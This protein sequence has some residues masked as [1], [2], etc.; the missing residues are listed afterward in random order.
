MLLAV[1]ASAAPLAKLWITGESGTGAG[2]TQI[3]LGIAADPRLPGHIFVTETG[4]KRI[5]E[6]DP[7]G[8]FVKA[9][10]WG[11]RDGGAQLQACTA[12]TG[13]ME[14]LGGS[15]AGQIDSPRGLAVDSEGNIFVFEATTARV[16]KF[17]PDGNFLLM[18]G[19]GVDQ[20]PNHPG[21]VCTAA[22]LAEG[23]SCGAGST[24]PAPG[25]FAHRDYLGNS[26]AIDSNDTIYVGDNERIEKF[27]SKGEFLGEVTSPF[28][29]GKGLIESLAI[30]GSGHFY[31]A[32]QRS[33]EPAFGS[34]PDVFKMDSTGSQICTLKVAN[35]KGLT[36]DRLGN[37]YV[38]DTEGAVFPVSTVEQFDPSCT[39]QNLPFAGDELTN[40][41][42]IGNGSA[43]L[44][45]GSDIYVANHDPGSFGA[46]PHFFI[47]AYGPPPDDP[48]CPPPSN[49]PTI[50]S[51]FATSAHTDA[52]TVKASINP[53]F[54]KDTVAYVEYGTGACSL[55]A[56][57]STANAPGVPLG[58]GVIDEYVTSGGVL[59]PNLEAGTEYHYRFVAKSSG[60]GPVYGVDPDGDGPGRANFEE[61]LEGTFTTPLPPAAEVDNCPNIAYRQGPASRLGDCRAYE[62]VSPV[63]KEES[64]ILTLK[65]VISL[66]AR[67][68]RAAGSGERF[69][70]STFRAFGDAQSS[71]YV[72][73]YLA[74]RGAAGW[75]NHAISP[76]R[77]G[78]APNDTIA[79]E[80]EF[81]YFS[82]DLA[83]AWVV[84]FT[85][86]LLAP[87]A[88]A[89]FNNLYHRDNPTDTYTAL[90][91]SEPQ[92]TTPA[93]YQIEMQGASADGSHTV[94]RTNDHAPPA[95][96]AGQTYQVYESVNGNL[97]P[98]CILPNKIR[99]KL[100]CSAGTLN[101]G[102]VER[103]A[104]LDHAISDDG[105]R[106]FWSNMKTNIDTGKL[107]VRI[108][109]DRTVAV[110]DAVNPAKPPDQASF[111]TAAADGSKAIF[112][113]GD[114]LYE[115]D[116][117]TRTA[118]LIA[119]GVAGVAGASDDASR[120]Y[121]VSRETLGGGPGPQ[122][123][124]PNLYLYEAGEPPVFNYVAT[125]AESDAEPRGKAFSPIAAEPRFNTARVSPDGLHLAF[126][127]TAS[128]TGKDNADVNSGK[129]DAEVFVFD[130]ETGLVCVSCNRTGARPM[131]RNIQDEHRLSEAF[132]VAAQ[133]PTAESQS[134][135]SRFFSDD[136][137]RLFFESIQPL[138]YGD[139][140]GKRD[141]YEW[142]ALGKGTCVTALG[143]YAP[144][145]AG[146]VT[147]ISS[148]GSTQDSELID[149]SADGSDVFFTTS[150]S[151][152]PQDPG[153][154]DVYDARVQGGFPQPRKTVVCEG[155]ACQAPPTPPND[156][157]P[158]SA[159]FNGP[160]NAPPGE[161]TECP[162]RRKRVKHHDKVRCLK[163]RH[164]K[165]RGSDR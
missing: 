136:G 83:Q 53:H 96:V 17:D 126:M 41:T 86:P 71:P 57:T 45:S 108:D 66:P 98:V 120:V 103:S 115:F 130:F 102:T 64:D 104:T 85:E 151:L 128:L 81:K 131:G 75:Q 78:S 159:I 46:P 107:Y 95:A 93:Q 4:N 82:E 44:T 29:A 110:S 118:K 18:F 39:N 10:G 73:Q 141:V 19:G 100:S 25:E 146:C 154:V 15:G 13:C 90:S 42:G 43:C 117:E 80:S 48:A 63:D 32:F 142:E 11:V 74:Q 61:G 77:E 160:G 58:A 134:Y 114:K 150:A 143:S 47:R 162:R 5:S 148:G 116:V 20:G 3:P 137:R 31:V 14:G 127:S 158:S 121:L 68:D 112:T 139:T 84:H 165:S 52:A 8:R 36:T 157:T 124:K 65:N 92:S 51:Q 7:W 50:A 21:N 59:L 106:I 94:F 145:L 155:E 105:S 30:D 26:I 34:G 38:I 33:V 49:P 37:A 97:N 101:S 138:A 35:P 76:P 54:W 149:S 87:G 2:Q 23:D 79:L 144:A 111:W 28:L 91:T 67:R 119:A 72:S 164:V 132:W 156:P 153:L 69:T 56:C 27:D 62:M 16:Q 123:G 89:G 133:I 6:F 122:V 125:L 152:V 22:F 24:G 113:V 60:G 109:G 163:R 161:R 40:A 55:G 1:P 147:L 140:N 129:A 9:W 88:V 135:S 70:Y 99:S 12:A